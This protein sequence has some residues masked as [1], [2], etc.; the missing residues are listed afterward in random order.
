MCKPKYEGERAEAFLSLFE[1]DKTLQQIAKLRYVD[2][3]TLTHTAMVVGYSERHI[4]RLC[5]V[6]EQTA[7]LLLEKESCKLCIH[8]AVCLEWQG[9]EDD[10]RKQRPTTEEDFLRMEHH[11]D[12]GHFRREE[13]E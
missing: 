9:I 2:G 1:K 5:K 3:M 7:E 6:I 12:C 10:A 4:Q 11:K 8:Y 13:T